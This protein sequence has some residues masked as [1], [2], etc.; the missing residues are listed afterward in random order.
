MMKARPLV[1]VIALAAAMN[2]CG[3]CS[4]SSETSSAGTAASQSATPSGTSTTPEGKKGEAAGGS[5]PLGQQMFAQ[6]L[7]EDI[8]G[9]TDIRQG[10]K[11]AD[12]IREV[13]ATHNADLEEIK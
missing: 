3:A 5:S 11:A 12:K 13:S 9:G 1:K 10:R 2:F 8:S 6:K 7:V 4:K